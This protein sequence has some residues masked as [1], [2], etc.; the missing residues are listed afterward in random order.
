MVVNVL[1]PK[2]IKTVHDTAVIPFFGEMLH[3]ENSHAEVYEKLL[4]GNFV[5]Q[6]SETNPLRKI[7]LDKVMMK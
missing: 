3:I 6:L 4:N 7:K 1:S 5:A 2:I